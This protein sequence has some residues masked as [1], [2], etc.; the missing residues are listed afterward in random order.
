MT[1]RDYLREK[2]AEQ[3]KGTDD[4]WPDEEDDWFADL[5]KIR[6]GPETPEVF[7]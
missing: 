5:F 3:Y 1:F 7:V 2:F 4:M 6:V